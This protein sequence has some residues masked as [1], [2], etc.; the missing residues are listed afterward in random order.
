MLHTNWSIGYL[1]RRCLTPMLDAGALEVVN[2]APALPDTPYAAMYKREQRST[3]VS[4]IV[5]LAQQTCDFDRM[6]QVA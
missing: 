2:V 6:F 1:P 4:S 5:K 3:V